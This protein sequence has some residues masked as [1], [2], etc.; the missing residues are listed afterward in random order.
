MFF[1]QVLLIQPNPIPNKY[2]INGYYYQAILKQKKWDQKAISDAIVP[3]LKFEEKARQRKQMVDN[4]YAQADAI[5]ARAV[6]KIFEEGKMV[7]TK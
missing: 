2:N 7:R 1:E 4:M 5:F 3:L 6:A